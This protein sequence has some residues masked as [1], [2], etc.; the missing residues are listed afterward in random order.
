MSLSIS[1]GEPNPT[2]QLDDAFLNLYLHKKWKCFWFYC[3]TKSPCEARRTAHLV[4]VSTRFGAC[5]NRSCDARETKKHRRCWFMSIDQLRWWF[6]SIVSPNAHVYFPFA[7]NE[8]DYGEV[9]GNKRLRSSSLNLS[10]SIK[11]LV[12][13]PSLAAPLRYIESSNDVVIGLWPWMT[14]PPPTPLTCILLYV[15]KI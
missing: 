13:F 6:M 4:V 12:C 11:L 3:P 14:A 10:S 8:L 7:K 2:S 1:Q 5:R 9:M 15:D